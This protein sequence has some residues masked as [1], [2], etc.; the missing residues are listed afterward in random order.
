MALIKCPECGREISDKATACIHCGFPLGQE[1]NTESLSNDTPK[2]IVVSCYKASDMV[3]DIILAIVRNVKGISKKESKTFVENG[4][5]ITIN[6]LDYETACVI[7]EKIAEAFREVPN[8]FGI[9]SK[10]VDADEIVVL[11]DTRKP[12][13]PCCPKCGATSIA[14]VNRGYSFVWGFFGSGKPVNVC[15]V[16][17]YKFRPGE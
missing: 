3:Y 14:T 10:I 17:G 13:I 5:P 4:L 9:E 16:C 15:Q 1:T 2:K 11:T 6:N 12:K 8:S 7:N